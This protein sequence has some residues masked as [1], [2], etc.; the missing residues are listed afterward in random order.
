MSLQMFWGLFAS[1]PAKL[2]NLLALLLT[3]PGGMLLHNARRRA[4]R[5]MASLPS[6]EAAIDLLTQRV[7]RFYYSLGFAFLAMALLVSWIST[8]I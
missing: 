1:H 4:S 6:S 2:V 5:A 8:W 3:C 7:N